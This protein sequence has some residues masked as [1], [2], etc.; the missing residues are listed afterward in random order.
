MSQVGDGASVDPDSRSA[1]GVVLINYR[2]LPLIERQLVSGAL[3]GAVVVIVDNASD[4][5]GVLDLGRRYGAA[6]VLVDHNSGFAGGVNRGIGSL[7]SATVDAYL[8]LNPDVEI[9]LDQVQQLH[10]ELREGGHAAVGPIIVD[11]GGRPWVSTSGG[12]VT[13][14]SVIW[15]FSGLSHLLPGLSG[16]FWTRRQI[17]TGVRLRP[18]WLCGAALL[19]DAAAWER[20]GT[21]PEDEVVYGE[22][23]GWGMRCTAAGGSL[24][25]VR[26]VEVRHTGG[27]SGASDVW[28]DATART[29]TRFMGPVRGRLAAAVMRIGV[30]GR[31]G[32]RR[33]LGR[34]LVTRS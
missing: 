20:F 17:R 18:R 1:L 28:V 23:V 12:P 13:L 21:M 34:P 32:L 19:I 22:D 14:R 10:R 4:P 15:Y 26:S 6:T 31:R 16:F 30:A 29:F 25:V 7:A 24:A 5:A 11:D 33:V 27:A 2:C 3:E 9:G 8:L